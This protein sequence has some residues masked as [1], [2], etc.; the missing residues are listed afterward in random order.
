MAADPAAIPVA[1][2]L[3]QPYPLPAMTPDGAAARFLM[4]CGSI[5][6]ITLPGMNA[7]EEA[8]LRKGTVRA[9]LLTADGALLWLFQFLRSTRTPTLTFECPFDIRLLSPAQR[10]IPAFEH[11]TRELPIEVH[12]VDE[13]G[14]LRVLRRISLPSE[15][16]RDFLAAVA[17]QLTSSRSGDVAH[18]LWQRREPA[19]LAAQCTMH[20]CGTSSRLRGLFGRR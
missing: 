5:L 14:I 6:Q 10:D 15:L 19:Q 20:V 7:S 1:P 16:T 17:N 11:R 9:G 13:Q 18:L 2:G 8:A 4:K 12:V 3:G